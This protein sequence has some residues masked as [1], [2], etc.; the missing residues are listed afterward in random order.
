ME[1][2]RGLVLKRCNEMVQGM[3]SAGEEVVGAWIV[4]S[5]KNVDELDQ[6]RDRVLV[7]STLLLT[8]YAPAGTSSCSESASEST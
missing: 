3:C 8:A 5:A 1:G 4:W 6:P 7:L 2:E